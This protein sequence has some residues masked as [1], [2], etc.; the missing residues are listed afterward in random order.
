MRFALP[1]P[2]VVMFLAFHLLFSD[3]PVHSA[4]SL[5][6][7]GNFQEWTEGVP[8]DWEVAIGAKNGGDQP[9]SKVA[10]IK[11]PALMLQGDASTMAWNS[12][13]QEIAARSGGQYVLEF[14]ARTK[15]V[16]REGRQYDNCYVGVFH[17]DPAKK[18][19][20]PTVEDVSIDGKGW[21][22]HRVEFGVPAG[23]TS[24]AVVIFL[25]KT[26][27]L[28]VKDVSVKEATPQ[29]PFRGSRR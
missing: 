16:K 26:G 10:P 19:V 18:V 3:N 17:F 23:A 9:I 27:I 8:N 14:E 7:N 22:R 21:T 11:G 2:V 1:P 4:E 13:S 29:R 6:T 24:T 25:S 28:G 5:V 20:A 15:D 12:V